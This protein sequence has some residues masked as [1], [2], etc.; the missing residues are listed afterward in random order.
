MLFRLLFRLF[1]D[2]FAIFYDVFRFHLLF[3]LGLCLFGSRDENEM[4]SLV[5]SNLALSTLLLSASADFGK[6][7]SASLSL[8]TLSLKEETMSFG[9]HTSF[10]EANSITSEANL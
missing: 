2:Q 1:L 8:S 6:P 3:R 4:L 5:A 7:T 10:L 9:W